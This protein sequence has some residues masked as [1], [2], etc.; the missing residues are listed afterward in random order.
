M[1]FLSKLFPKAKTPLLFVAFLSLVITYLLKDSITA[2]IQMDSE[3]LEL[4]LA[5]VFLFFLSAMGV[6]LFANMANHQKD[7]EKEI[8]Q[9]TTENTVTG[10]IGT[11]I[12]NTGLGH[13]NTVSDSEATHITNNSSSS[14]TDNKKK[15]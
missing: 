7:K 12:S 6:A 15:A 5:F 10:S 3:I 13:K 2:A 9:N 8:K 14:D 1:E 4:V 11:T